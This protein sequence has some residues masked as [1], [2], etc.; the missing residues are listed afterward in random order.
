MTWATSSS[1]S[2][3]SSSS[4][5]SSGGR[6]RH[7][8]QGRKTQ[9]ASFV[10]LL[11]ECSWFAEQSLSYDVLQWRLTSCCYC[12]CCCHYCERFASLSLGERR[13]SNTEFRIGGLGIIIIAQDLSWDA[14]LTR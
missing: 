3:S 1:C 12:C 10:G 5:S 8:G 7:P 2:S 9:I 6:R 13:H 14:H 11:K 4:S